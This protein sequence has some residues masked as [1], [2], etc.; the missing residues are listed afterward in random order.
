M[1][2][3]A[4]HSRN[5]SPADDTKRCRKCDTRAQL[6]EQLAQIEA[7]ERAATRLQQARQ[8]VIDG[9]AHIRARRQ[10]EADI[11]RELDGLGRLRPSHRARR[12]ELE[13]A[14]PGLGEDLAATR[15]RLAPIL[16]Q[17]PALEV[18]HTEGHRLMAAAAAI[19]VVGAAL[20][21]HRQ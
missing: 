6:A 9:R 7:A 18:Y 1:P 5:P 15:E 17:G 2:R 16:A 19:R 21:A 10:R 12:R 20:R 3:T 8:T 14:L 13:A 4:V 11:A